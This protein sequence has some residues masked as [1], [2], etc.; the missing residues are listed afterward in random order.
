MLMLK[1]WVTASYSSKVANFN[2][3]SCVWCPRRGD[4]IGILP[5]YLASEN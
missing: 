1:L 5:W 2:H 4:P 3:P